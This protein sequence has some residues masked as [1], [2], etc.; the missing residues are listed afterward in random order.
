MAAILPEN[1]DN[2]KIKYMI[3]MTAQDI[4][5]LRQIF[6]GCLK[7]GHKG[8]KGGGEK[9]EEAGF[10]DETKNWTFQS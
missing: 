7:V 2:R 5:T 8:K 6:S 1:K 10:A 4:Q 9:G 3:A